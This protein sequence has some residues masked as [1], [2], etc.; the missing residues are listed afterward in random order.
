MDTLR[1]IRGRAGCES[2]FV[3]DG[4]PS[5]AY[6]KSAD[7][8]GFRNERVRGFKANI[9]ARMRLRTKDRLRSRRSGISILHALE[10]APRTATE[11]S[12]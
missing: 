11:H 2:P 10:L 7:L 5:E 3:F 9:A 8:K 4:Q 1:W 6:P 12:A